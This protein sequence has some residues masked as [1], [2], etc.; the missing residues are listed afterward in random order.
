MRFVLSLLACVA[1]PVAALAQEMRA[2]T[3]SLIYR[4]RIAL[5]PEAEMLLELR[6]AGGAVVVSEALPTEGAQVPLP[7]AVQA[8][9]GPA[10]SLRAALRL[11][12]QIRWLSDTVAIE[13]GE[14]PVQAG[15]VML[16]GFRPMGFATTLSC[17]ELTAELGFVGQGARLRIGGQY[18]KLVPEVTASGAK[19]V[20]EGDPETWVWTKGDA[21]TLRLHGAEFPECRA[22]L[23]GGSYRARGNEP[24][25]TLEIAGGQ[26][27]Y[28][29]DYGATGIAA[30][31]PEPGIVDDAR[32]YAPEGADLVLTLA[33]ALCRD[34]MTG[35]PYPDT[36]SV[37]TGGQRLTG[38]GGDPLDL[39]AAH[40]WRIEDI[41]GGGIIDSS[42]V[43][44]AFGRD[45]RV[46]GSGGCNR[47][48]GGAELT[49]EGLRIG[50]VGATLMACPEA[51]MMQERRV[52][53]VLD[54]VDR[55]D[56]SEDGAL[57]LIG[58][59]AVLATARR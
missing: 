55:F 34:T 45:G 2:I 20:A 43:T 54:R 41:G 17:G 25:W 27:R 8:P 31:L 59:D 4:E 56:V 15:E 52:F 13:A 30:P 50:P 21:A 53:E 29:G 6:D 22:A 35:M 57:L 47:F 19:F 28:A 42:N 16:K 18:V 44:I 36:A 3:G 12:G 39:L 23:P 40:P 58:G 49:G 32:R 9:A 14:G 46:S 11:D 1:L 38:C 37:E 5:S 51:L 7:F 48:M 10:F 24:G 26:M 33:P